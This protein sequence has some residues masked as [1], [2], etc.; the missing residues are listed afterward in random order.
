MLAAAL[1]LGATVTLGFLAGRMS[2]GGEAALRIAPPTASVTAA[3][4]ERI[5]SWRDLQPRHSVG[6]S[7][8]DLDALQD[9][10]T[11]LLSG[12]R[13]GPYVVAGAVRWT[14]VKL[15]ADQDEEEEIVV[16]V[17]PGRDWGPGA[18]LM[19]DDLSDPQVAILARRDV[20]SN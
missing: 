6:L 13:G 3:A 20:R 5:G 18:T 19:V 1:I 17:G 12:P 11:Y 16:A 9:G 15:A 8:A 14:G 10:Y 2:V 7:Q 4:S